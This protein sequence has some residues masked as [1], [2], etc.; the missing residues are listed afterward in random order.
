MGFAALAVAVTPG[1]LQQISPAQGRICQMTRAQRSALHLSA[2][3][4]QGVETGCRAKENVKHAAFS[5]RLAQ[6]SPF[7]PLPGKK[8][9]T[10]GGR[11]LCYGLQGVPVARTSH[12]NVETSRFSTLF[13]RLLGQI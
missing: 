11:R 6:L 12:F 8:L 9:A 1:Q 3:G 7:T 13:S 10:P 2:S 5:P 4:L